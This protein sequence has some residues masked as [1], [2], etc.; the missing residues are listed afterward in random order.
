MK[1]LYA[2]MLST[3]ML[4]SGIAS[5]RAE[6]VVL[7]N[8]FEVPAG[9]EETAI[10]Y[11]KA[12]RDFLATQPGFV[13][14]RLHRSIGASARFQLVNVA[15]WSSAEAF[16]VASERMRKELGRPLPEGLKF[17]PALYQVIR[18]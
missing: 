14:T 9:G 4:A 11:W 18:K 17:T 15:E 5:A 12:A 8:L 2:M 16:Q 1:T 13:A 3:A 6:N 10:H 7:I